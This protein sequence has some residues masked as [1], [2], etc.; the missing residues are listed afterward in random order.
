MARPPPAS[1]SGDL[2]RRSGRLPKLPLHLGDRQNT[3]PPIAVSL[4]SSPAM[5]TAQPI[6]PCSATDSTREREAE[7]R[8]RTEKI[9]AAC[10]PSVL[11]PRDH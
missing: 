8:K 10:V 4:P 6:L 7:Q 2:R 5:P 3:A 1:V 9:S 11:G